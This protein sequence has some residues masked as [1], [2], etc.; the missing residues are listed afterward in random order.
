MDWHIRFFT[1]WLLQIV[2]HFLPLSVYA[3][4]ILNYPSFY[5]FHAFSYIWGQVPCIQVQIY[6][7]RTAKVGTGTTVVMHLDLQWKLSLPNLSTT[8]KALSH[9]WNLALIQQYS[10]HSL[11][12]VCLNCL[13]IFY[14]LF[15][16]PP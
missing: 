7:W 15:F 12:S 3:L 8:M 6:W 16:S 1:I 11:Y 5:T 9:T 10:I 13:N 4:S 14:N 2:L